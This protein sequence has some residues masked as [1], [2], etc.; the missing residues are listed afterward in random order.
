MYMGSL[1]N[2]MT[3][4]VC[5]Y[6]EYMILIARSAFL[7]LKIIDNEIF[8]YKQTLCIGFILESYHICSSFGP[9]S[10]VTITSLT[11]TLATLARLEMSL[12]NSC[13]CSNEVRLP[14]AARA[15]AHRTSAALGQ[16]WILTAAS[17]VITFS[18]RYPEVTRAAAHR[19]SATLG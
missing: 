19:T 7:F 14:V 12:S 5:R 9:W 11:Q 17:V 15:A 10:P 13:I 2:Y 1:C 6:F 18:G 8:I 3:I 4:L 16:D